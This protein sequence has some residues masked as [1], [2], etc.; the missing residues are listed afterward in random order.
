VAVI[1]VP[2]PRVVHEPHGLDAIELSAGR[3]VT[4]GHGP[5]HVPAILLFAISGSAG[6]FEVFLIRSHVV[7]AVLSDRR[8]SN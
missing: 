4:T 6:V 5:N 8:E 2:A 1:V 3:E 7:P